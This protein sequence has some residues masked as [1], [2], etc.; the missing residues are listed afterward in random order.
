MM[1]T[2]MGGWSDAAQHGN[3]AQPSGEDRRARRRRKWAG[4]EIAVLVIAFVI[5]WELGLAFL[6]L[7]LW[8]QASGE[9]G[10]VFAFARRKWE[11]LVAATSTLLS[12]GSLPFAANFGPKSSGNLAFDEWRQGE[13]ARI[14]AE[15]QK[16]QAA[17]RDFSAYREELLRAR[18][19]EAFE[20][21]MQGRRF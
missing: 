9:E 15:R 10:S 20:R 7:K 5:R 21:F 1:E 14:E 12:N 11:G 13:L 19:R 4:P 8:H 3:W 2:I 18:D 17:E 16:L 6:A